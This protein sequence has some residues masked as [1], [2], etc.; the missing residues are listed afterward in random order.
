[1]IRTITAFA[2]IGMCFFHVNASQVVKVHPQQ[3]QHWNHPA[4]SPVQYK[5]LKHHANAYA[6]TITKTAESE[7]IRITL[8]KKVANWHQQHSNGLKVVFSQPDLTFGQIKTLSL[9]LSLNKQASSIPTLAQLN[10][11]YSKYIDSG[12]IDIHWLKELLSSNG[13]INIKF[14]GEHHEDQNIATTFANYQLILTENMLSS[15]KINRTKAIDISLSDFDIYRQ[16]NWQEQ[17]V[18][19]DEIASVTVIGMLI[20][21]ETNNEKTLRSYL[22]DHYVEEIPEYFIELAISLADLRLQLAD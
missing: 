18:S 20:T 8:I 17:Q 9:Q 14:F 16:I 19:I 2:L 4:T 22:Q 12:L 10:D 7:Q 15:T 13:V 6:P 21:A 3:V 5:A 11:I 1:M